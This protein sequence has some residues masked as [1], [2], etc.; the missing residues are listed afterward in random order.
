MLYLPILSEEVDLIH[1]SFNTQDDVE[2]VIHLNAD[3]THLMFQA[4]T[5]S[6]FGETIPHLV[7]VVAQV[8]H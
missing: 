6:P 7:L 1:G 4:G 3:R 8:V 2:L 5:Q